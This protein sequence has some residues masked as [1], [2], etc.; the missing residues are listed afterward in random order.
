MT[1]QLRAVYLVGDML[2]WWAVHGMGHGC[3]IGCAGSLAESGPVGLGRGLTL[4]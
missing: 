3:V 4:R 2:Q 1:V